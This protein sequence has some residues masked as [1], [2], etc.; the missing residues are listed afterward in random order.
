MRLLITRPMEDATPL[1]DL[2]AARGHETVIEPLLE[3]RY[4]AIAKADIAALQDGVQALLVTSANGL[5]AFAGCSD[6]RDV[7]VVA[8]GEASARAAISAGF[9]DV[10]SADGDV[11]ALAALV[12]EKRNPEDGPLLHVAGSAMA[13]D[14]SGLLQEAGFD[15]RRA[16]LYEAVQAEHLSPPVRAGIAAGKFDGV[17]LFSPRTAARFA[18]LVSAAGLADYCREMTAYC[19]SPAVAKKAGRFGWARLAI[20]ARPDQK[21]LIEIIDA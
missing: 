9:G 10:E 3:I 1:A 7:A 16:V 15:V 11:A 19:L 6:R 8:V 14:L 18:A 12:A 5:R 2:L 13:G 20:A 4:L 21:S 17:V